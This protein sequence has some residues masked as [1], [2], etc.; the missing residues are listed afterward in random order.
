MRTKFISAIAAFS[1][2]CIPWTSAQA[3]PSDDL[4]VATQ[5]HVDSPKVFWERNNFTLNAEVDGALHPLQSTVNWVGKGYKPTGE[6]QYIYKIPKDN[7]IPG[8]GKPG[9]LLYQAPILP[10]FSNSPIWAGFGADID[11]PA[12]KFKDRS[13]NL[14]LV[15]FDGPG[16][17]NLF[18]SDDWLL[19]SHIPGMRSAW[20]NPGSHT[21]NL[22]T[23]TKPGTYTLTYRASAR[24]QKGRFIAS[25]P[26]RLVWQVGGTKPTKGGISDPRA[27]YDAAPSEGDQ[28]PSFT[29]KPHEG[30]D[31]DGDEHLSD[32]LFDAGNDNASGT[33][34]FYIDGYHL[35]E[36]PV[37]NG[38]AAWTEMV[39]SAPSNFQVVFIPTQ[40]GKKWISAPVRY[41]S[42]AP[43]VSTTNP[44][45]FPQKQTTSPAPAF[46]ND[47]RPV[48]SAKVK[49]SATSL[50]EEYARISAIPEDKNLSFRVVGGFYDTPNGKYP[51]CEIDFISS[52]ARRQM[53]VPQEGCTGSKYT[54]KLRLL[55]NSRTN[56]GAK[57]IRL[58][59]PLPKTGIVTFSSTPY[60]GR[61]GDP[62]SAHPLSVD[63]PTGAPAE[64][65]EQLPSG[66]EPAPSGNKPAKPTPAPPTKE[67]TPPKSTKKAVI[68]DGHVDVRAVQ[69]GNGLAMVLGDDSGSFSKK[70]MVHDL[71]K[72][73]LAVRPQA[74]AKRSKHVFADASFNFLGPHGTE[75]FVLPQDQ[76]SGLVW[77]GFSTQELDY[78]HFPKGVD[79]E[80]KPHSGPKGAKWWAF[81]QNLGKLADIIAAS[82]RVSTLH[83]TNR[84]HL[85]TNW[86]FTKQGRYQIQVRAKDVATGKYSPWYPISFQVGAATGKQHPRQPAGPN[87]P[88]Y[89]P[90]A[91][92]VPGTAGS[93]TPSTAPETS[94][95]DTA[96]QSPAKPIE[97]SSP[98]EDAASG[99]GNAPANSDSNQPA[100]GESSKE[101]P[102]PSGPARVTSK[103][104]ASPLAKTGSNGMAEQWLT[105]LGAVLL[106]AG[107]ALAFTSIRK[108]R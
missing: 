86:A 35:A 37:Q 24:D 21:H 64:V 27:A 79:I 33:A 97:G 3:G 78:S 54:L 88:G 57:T 12:D 70:P 5:A 40:G 91:T 47:D 59:Y 34:L 66:K 22:T 39:G 1:A 38:K 30:R 48:T 104:Y 85:H 61:S 52:P 68:S 53:V 80:I 95:N 67:V 50:D 23:F 108:R 103:P 82:D 69:A 51:S 25:A 31:K 77:P 101:A 58:G 15:G 74:R 41:Q 92:T 89:T 2:L 10:G 20:I 11:I 46:A 26:Q 60:V 75:L 83:T 96:V 72:V 90:A 9:T 44:G 106:G 7:T 100:D 56:V 42:A 17:M 102:A 76:K 93:G 29:L 71:A 105:I 94:G 6:Q 87:K 14:D 107:A 28:S 81:T 55:P 63:A 8:L 16:E 43:Q 62:I 73:S 18:K 13:F 98:G 49:L 45:S 19:A 99:D 4:L 65:E 32:L 36:V 84:T